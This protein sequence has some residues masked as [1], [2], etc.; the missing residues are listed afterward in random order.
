M[1][2]RVKKAKASFGVLCLPPEYPET[3]QKP[4]Q[5]DV[6]GLGHSANRSAEQAGGE[7][8][9]PTQLQG[10]DRVAARVCCGFDCQLLSHLFLSVLRRKPG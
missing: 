6:G 9:W 7:A 4:G 8:P 5:P 1:L 10:D 3:F 2:G